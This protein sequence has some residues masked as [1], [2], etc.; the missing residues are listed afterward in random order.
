M[1]RWEN[2]W[3]G[4]KI[5]RRIRINPRKNKWDFDEWQNEMQNLITFLKNKIPTE[6]A[7]GAARL[8]VK[9]I[10]VSVIVGAPF[11]LHWISI[12]SPFLLRR[13]KS[14]RNFFV[15]LFEILQE[16]KWSV[17]CKKR[18]KWMN[19]DEEFHLFSKLVLCIF[20]S[21]YLFIK[22]VEMLVQ[23]TTSCYFFFSFKSKA[24]LQYTIK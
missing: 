2:L 9:Y 19:K 7:A 14:Y 17:F 18:M 4:K 11:P 24:I 8:I 23:L 1:Y 20:Q 21:I 22:R 10:Y 5:E 12:I 13:T 3:F 6:A 15:L 16:H